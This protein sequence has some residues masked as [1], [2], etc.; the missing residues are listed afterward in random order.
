MTTHA[1][2]CRSSHIKSWRC[3]D[4]EHRLWG[5]SPCAW[6]P[7][8][9]PTS[10]VTSGNLTFLLCS[11]TVRWL[12]YSK[13]Q[14]VWFLWCSDSCKAPRTVCGTYTQHV[15]YGGPKGHAKMPALEPLRP[16]NKLCHGKRDSAAIS[17]VTDLKIGEISLYYPGG[18]RTRALKSRRLSPSG[19]I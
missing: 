9:P 13:W 6:S 3:H 2:G 17:K 5:Q 14:I 7:L 12:Q 15:R 1:L 18:S 8:V 16:V 19:G 10:C 11:P 4:K